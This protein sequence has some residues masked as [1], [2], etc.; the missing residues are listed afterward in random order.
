[1]PGSG[2]ECV[3]SVGLEGTWLLECC[4]YWEVGEMEH[5]VT[6][7]GERGRSQESTEPCREF[8]WGFALLIS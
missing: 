2:A 1:M 8:L 3:V 7:D 6:K 4:E 5:L